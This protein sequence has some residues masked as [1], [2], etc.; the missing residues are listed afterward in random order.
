MGDEA[1]PYRF[2]RNYEFT[3]EDVQVFRGR[4]R[5][6][7]CL[8]TEITTRHL[9]VLFAP[10]GTGKSSLINAAVRPQLEESDY[11][12]LYIKP[13]QDVRKS[14]RDTLARE[15]LLDSDSGDL[16]AQL[17]AAA[18]LADQPVV[19]FFDQFEEFFLNTG[20]ETADASKEFV[21]AVA[22]LYRDRSSGVY[23][24]F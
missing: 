18:K 22:A 11:K 14:I 23:F 24:F 13:K 4:S 19:L 6:A 16:A 3:K 20:D 17:R 10:T 1:L 8:F 9:V 5:E 2:L 7:A 12:T 21:Q 15:R